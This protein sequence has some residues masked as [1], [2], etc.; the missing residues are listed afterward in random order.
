MLSLPVCNAA[1]LADG[2][3]VIKS[4]CINSVL[5]TKSSPNPLNLF[6]PSL[7]PS[8]SLSISL[9]LSPSLSLYLS[10]S[11]TLS[12]PLYLSLYLFIALSLSP[13]LSLS[14]YLPLS[15]SIFL[16]LSPSPWAIDPVTMVT[17]PFHSCGGNGPL[18][19]QD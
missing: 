8:L 16:S 5:L 14:F 11:I 13:S 12:L 19:L 3:K 1:F 9:S 15:L 4:Y 10:L 17:W 2:L 7:S 6:S 18:D